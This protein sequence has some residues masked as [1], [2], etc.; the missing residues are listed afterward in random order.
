[1]IPA[2]PLY[3]PSATRYDTMLY[4]RCGCSGIKL[5]ALSLGLWNNFGGH[6]NFETARSLICR[7]F[8]LGITHFDL[9][10]NYGPP[11]GSAELTFGRVLRENLSAH[12]DELFISTKAG[13]GM[14]GGP[15]GSYGGSRKYLIAGLDASLLRMGLDYVDIF[16]H[17]TPD[18]ETPLEETMGA[19]AQIVRAGKALYVGL[20]SY[21][22]QR[23][24]EAAALLRGMGVSCLLHQPAYNLFDRTYEQGLRQVLE[25]EG[26]GS[27]AFIPLAQGL[28]TNKYLHG[29]PADSRAARPTGT[30]DASAITEV[31]IAMVQKLNAIAQARGQSLAQMALAWVLAQGVTS[32]LIGASRV[33]QI[34]ENV[35][36]LQNLTFSPEELVAINTEVEITGSGD[37]AS[38]RP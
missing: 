15:Y 24:R 21:G 32:A 13:W 29:I 23:T 35:G 11:V 33:T 1:M 20:S 25:E 36:A 27:I 34:E 10:D 26:I 37:E 28:L 3:T 38:T 17:H 19:L 12:R 6:D 18:E 5:P 22:P 30:L 7:S 16:Y 8:D 9:A 14:W 4:R 2:L 31:K